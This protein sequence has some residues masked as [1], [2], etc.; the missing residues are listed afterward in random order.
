MIYDVALSY[1]ELFLTVATWALILS[2]I[3]IVMLLVTK[4]YSGSDIALLLIL[5]FI[6]AFI[7]NLVFNPHAT[8]AP[9]PDENIPSWL[10]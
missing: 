9:V 8:F 4:K 2:P 5:F 7:L 6:V 10:R 3:A 1:F